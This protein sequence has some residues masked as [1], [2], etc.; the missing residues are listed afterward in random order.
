MTLLVVAW[1]GWLALDALRARDALTA[2]A[3]EVTALRTQVLAGDRPGAEAT[4]ADLQAHA[5]TA[6]DRTHGPHWTLVGAVPGIGPTVGA[7]QTVSEVVGALTTQALPALMDATALADPAALAPVDGRIDLAPLTAAA[8]GVVAADAAVHDALTTLRGVDA[9]AVVGPF[10]AQL[11]RLDAQLA[12]VA[13]TTATAARAVQLLPPML[14]ADGPRQY[15]LLVQNNAEPRATGGIPGSVVLL[16]A[17]DGRVETVDQRPGG[18]LGNLAA[19]VLPLTAQEEALFGPDLSAD[20]RDV[21]FTPDFPRSG[22]LARA[23]WQ[24]E[25]GGTVDG[26]LSIDPG[27]LAHVLG[28]TGPVALPGGRSLTADNAVALLL[29]TVYLELAPAA[30]DAFFGVTSDAVFHALVS[31]QGE[32]AAAVEALARSAGEGRLMVWSA[33]PQEQSLLSGTAVSG[34]LVGVR[35]DS[36]VLGVY[37]NDGSAAKMGYYLRRDVTVT[38]T[39]CTADGAQALTASVTLTST[40]PADAADLPPYLTGTLLPAGE[41]RTNV[42]VYAPSGGSVESVRVTGADPGVFA[43]THDGLAV[44]GK[45]VQLKPGESVRIDLDVVTG[46]GQTGD[47]VVRTTPMATGDVRTGP[48]GCSS[49]GATGR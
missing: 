44:V 22:E 8:P 46:P 32:P 30:Q 5:A 13:A 14:G 37:L 20:M 9:D 10:A 39:G 21:T 35:G 49:P 24:Q 33:H 31:G 29:N 18:S 7:V 38:S 19:P 45:T 27:A 34:E 42:L 28:A 47:A 17:A 16:R 23:I 41:L 36:P 43:Q 12:D 11:G 1:I 26:V 6:H 48:T 3:G 40:A 4:L 25:V 15:L 2:A